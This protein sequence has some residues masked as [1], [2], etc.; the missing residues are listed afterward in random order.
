MKLSDV[1]HVFVTSFDPDRRRG[2][3]GL[4]HANWYMFEPE[5]T[6][7][8]LAIDDELYRAEG[9]GELIEI[10]NEHKDL[11]LSFLVAEDCVLENV[12]LFPIP[13]YTPGSC[14]LLLGTSNHT[15]LICGDTIAT[16]EHLAKGI[17]LANS[18]NIE[19]AQESFKECVEI[20]DIIIPG[21]DNVLLSPY[22]S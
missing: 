5:I 17:V 11:L 18:S 12:D 8:A 3:E 4:E 22:R 9:D 13:G 20:A 6:S 14:G 10:L 7:A 16:Q 1:T 15:V 19:L 2:L 21:R